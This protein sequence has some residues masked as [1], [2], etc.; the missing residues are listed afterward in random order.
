[1][2]FI[3]VSV[4]KRSA[5]SWSICCN[6]SVTNSYLCASFPHSFDSSTLFLW[7]FPLRFPSRKII[8]LRRVPFHVVWT[9]SCRLS[10][11]FNFLFFTKYFPSLF[12]CD[13]W[14]EESMILLHIVY[15]HFNILFSLHSYRVISFICSWLFNWLQMC[16]HHWSVAKEFPLA[17][18]NVKTVSP[19]LKFDSNF[20]FN[21]QLFVPVLTNIISFLLTKIDVSWSFQMLMV[22]DQ[23]NIYLNLNEF[24]SLEWNR[25]QSMLFFRTSFDYWFDKDEMDLL[26]P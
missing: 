12:P 19:K 3:Q 14:K 25:I 18:S 17:F 6:L 1:M 5:N 10:T 8:P 11:M 15:I 7:L 9:R 26:F 16:G 2:H 13:L 23:S 22:S 24:L 4:P 21:I 20:L